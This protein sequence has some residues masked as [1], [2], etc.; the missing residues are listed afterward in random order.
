MAQI[1]SHS[2]HK[3]LNQHQLE[4]SKTAR[5]DV[6]KMICQ[7]FFASSLILKYNRQT[8]KSSLNLTDFDI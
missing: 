7:N 4:N 6:E 3:I 2:E 1:K 5:L 8:K